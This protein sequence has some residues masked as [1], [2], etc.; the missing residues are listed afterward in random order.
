MNNTIDSSVVSKLNAGAASAT[1]KSTSADLQENFMTLLVT[2]LQN[3]DPLKPMENAE[4]TSQLAQINTV[5][6]IEQ[7][8]TTLASITGQIEEG[9]ALQAAALVGRGVLVPGERVLVGSGVT[10]PF[11][12]E[13]EQAADEVSVTLVDSSGKAVRQFDLGNLKAGV[14]SFTWDGELEDG[15]AAPDGAYTVKVEARANGEA[16]SATTLNYAQVGGVTRTDAGP[17]L[18]LGAVQGSVSLADVRQIL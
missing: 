6:G 16:L 11:G 14:Q 7:L 1:T 17:L 3:Q 10:T 2:Q 12:I 18:D 13:L 4:L 5:N 9:Q 15:S 8:N